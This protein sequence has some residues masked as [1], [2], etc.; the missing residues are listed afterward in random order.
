MKPSVLNNLTTPAG[1]EQG[2]R[3]PASEGMGMGMD[4]ISSG[5][6]EG[7]VMKQA[8]GFADLILQAEREVDSGGPTPS[9]DAIVEQV[10]N[11]DRES[12][13]VSGDVPTVIGGMAAALQ[14]ASP[15][16]RDVIMQ[17][18]GNPAAFQPLQEQQSLQSQQAPLSG[19][20]DMAG[21][22]P[23]MGMNVDSGRPAMS[24]MN[25]A[26]PLRSLMNK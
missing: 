18:A 19:L 22:S 4:E 14:I 3:G 6:S 23:D 9:V 5:A 21:I 15:E 26:S 20:S 8:E 12:R 13:S 10:M 17:K 2:I 11:H 24:K 16:L 7:A 1:F 25:S